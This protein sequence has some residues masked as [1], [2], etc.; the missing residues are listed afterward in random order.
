M[1][2]EAK[3]LIDDVVIPDTEVQQ[4]KYSMKKGY[5]IKIAMNMKQTNFRC[6]SCELHAG[7]VMMDKVEHCKPEY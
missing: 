5:M 4:Y 1:G 2:V 6:L 7:D 3:F